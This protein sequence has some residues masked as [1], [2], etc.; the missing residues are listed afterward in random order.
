[1]TPVLEFENVVRAYIEGKPVLN[2]ATFRVGPGEVVGLLGRNGAGKTTLMRLAMGMLHPQVG[3]VRVFGLSPTE[4]P[5]AVKKRIGYVAENQVLPT[6]AS[7][8]EIVV[9]HRYLFPDWD[10]DLERQLVARFSV[11]MSAKIGK[12]SMGEARRVALLCAVCHRPE[13][14][15]LDEPAGGL[16]PAVRREFLEAVIQLLNR[17]GTS[18]L[19]STHQMGD[20]ERM[21]SRVVLLDGGCVRLDH[22]LD[23]LHEDFC[24]AMVPRSAAP[25]AAVLERVP[26]CLRA[27]AAHDDWHAV[28]QKPPEEAEAALHEALGID[29]VR[30]VRMPLEDLFIEM[31]GASR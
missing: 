1:M 20:V 22:E 6:G 28:F 24:V 21:G 31:V 10:M 26:G 8:E 29:G 23:R 25:N 13:L 4:Q 7:V 2:G 14:L 3:S 12:L 18:V 5:V 11:N 30:C 17:E 27:R 19:F 9:F 15:L 16:D